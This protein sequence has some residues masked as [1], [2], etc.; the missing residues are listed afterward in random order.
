MDT[1][2][3]NLQARQGEVQKALD[4]L[5]DFI[6]LYHDLDNHHS[7]ASN[8]SNVSFGSSL[9]SFK[10]LNNSHSHDTENYGLKELSPNEVSLVSLATDAVVLS[11][12]VQEILTVISTTSAASIEAH[13]QQLSRRISSICNG[14]MSA[15]NQSELER[16]SLNPNPPRQATAS[17]IE[18]A[19]TLSRTMQT[20]VMSIK[21]IHESYSNPNYSKSSEIIHSGQDLETLVSLV[22]KAVSKYASIVKAEMK[23]QYTEA[24]V[25]VVTAVGKFHSYVLNAAISSEVLDIE[26]HIQ[27]KYSMLNSL[28]TQIQNFTVISKQASLL[29]A[30]AQANEGA[31][32]A[33]KEVAGNVKDVALFMKNSGASR[34]LIEIETVDEVFLDL[35]Q[36]LKIQPRNSFS[37]KFDGA[38]KALVG[39]ISKLLEAG[40][41]TFELI[42]ASASSPSAS[43]VGLNSKR[44]EVFDS[45]AA[46]Q[47]AV[48]EVIQNVEEIPGFTQLKRRPS[49]IDLDYELEEE[50]Q[51]LPAIMS[52]I[53]KGIRRL[54]DEINSGAAASEDFLEMAHSICYSAQKLLS[55]VEECEPREVFSKKIKELLQKTEIAAGVWAPPGAV[56]DLKTAAFELATSLKVLREFVEGNDPHSKEALQKGRK[57]QFHTVSARDKKPT[58]GIGARIPFS[59]SSDNIQSYESDHSNASDERPRVTFKGESQRPQ[60]LKSFSTNDLSSPTLKNDSLATAEILDHYLESSSIGDSVTQ[61]LVSGV[62]NLVL[63]TKILLTQNPPANAFDNLKVAAQTVAQTTKVLLSSAIAYQNQM[64][65]L[66]R[67]ESFNNELTDLLLKKDEQSPNQSIRFHSDEYHAINPDVSIPTMQTISDEEFQK[68]MSD[69]PT[70]LIFEPESNGEI[71]VIRAGSIKQLVERLTYY[72][73]PDPD[74]TEAFLMTY[75]SFMLPLEL[76]QMIIQ[77]YE[78][79][80]PPNLTKK[81]LDTLY[82]VKVL[83]TR[84]RVVNVLK[85]WIDKHFE[86]FE[87]EEPLEG[88]LMHFLTNKTTHH[89]YHEDTFVHAATQLRKLFEKKKKKRRQSAK[90]LLYNQKIPEPILPK[91]FKNIANL[92]IS[93]IDPQELARQITDIEHNLYKA[94]QAKECL[95]Q[96]WN[97][98]ELK[99]RSPNIIAF[100]HRFNS[101]TKKVVVDILK[102][103]SKKTRAKLITYYITV[104]EKCRAL[105][106]FNALTAILAALTSSPVRRLSKTWEL[107]PKKSNTTCEQ[108]DSIVSH[109]SNYEKYRKI[110][111]SLH[112]PCVPFLGVYLTDLVFIEDGNKDVLNVNLINFDKRRKIALVIREIQQYQQ[113]PYCIKT[114]PEIQALLLSPDHQ[115]EDDLY[116]LSLELEPRTQ[117]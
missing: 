22:A 66:G 99:H 59:S 40:A 35:L 33:A 41:A 80:V 42:S 76:L 2:I 94:I 110:L 61:D 57:P 115:T 62:S 87:T 38:A 1:L 77:R 21:A 29:W 17:L 20:T 43:S 30:P 101:L 45:L 107:V 111:H 82:R 31:I 15:A 54:V 97:K 18:I 48:N 49:V 39:G 106:N 109:H 116:K 50:K 64:E 12:H 27:S 96:A 103:D 4:K 114:V 105:N 10:S 36:R 81:Q 104:A 90:L 6:K 91:T 9:G 37:T 5:L 72:K 100:I 93:D 56:S 16:R 95:N 34:Q 23:A 47:N 52:E 11:C 92:P 32:I 108:L 84:L 14:L 69:D 19:R 55:K 8:Y 58:D 78:E 51:Q 26:A 83:P 53:V 117:K 75:R 65:I 44:E 7:T 67:K 79:Q 68:L 46:I 98:P 24:A 73:Y 71:P 89:Y 28:V 102:S 70:D 13:L 3:L 86:D 74:F 88:C 113:T 85:I 60:I 63:L 112:P 25:E